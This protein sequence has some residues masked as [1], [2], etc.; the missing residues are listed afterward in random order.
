MMNKYDR[1]VAKGIKEQSYKEKGTKLRIYI[2]KKGMAT[3]RIL[4]RRNKTVQLTK[5]FPW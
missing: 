4:G 2:T 1:C 5:L 3:Q